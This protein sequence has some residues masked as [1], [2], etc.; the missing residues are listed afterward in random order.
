MSSKKILTR[1]VPIKKDELVESG[2]ESKVQ[3]QRLKVVE[4]SCLVLNVIIFVFS[5]VYYEMISE[6]I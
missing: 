2:Y 6:G 1:F 5:I 4:L 3:F